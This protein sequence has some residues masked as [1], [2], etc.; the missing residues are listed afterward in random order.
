MFSQ[1][2]KNEIM[3]TM[4]TALKYMTRN[5]IS[6]FQIKFNIQTSNM[7]DEIYL[8]VQYTLFIVSYSNYRSLGV[9]IFSRR[10][11]LS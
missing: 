5:T 11:V 3:V 9:D 4:A 7:I 10:A 8:N 6:L 2:K 1:N